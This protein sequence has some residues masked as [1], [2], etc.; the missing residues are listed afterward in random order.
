MQDAVTR[1]M[2]ESGEVLNADECITVEAALPA[3]TIDAAW[4]CRAD[5]VTGSIEVGK[6]ADLVVLEDDPTAVDPTSIANIAVYQTR[7]G[8]VVRFTCR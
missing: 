7:L 8:G 3:V 1:I 2:A 4:Q 6:Y 5:D